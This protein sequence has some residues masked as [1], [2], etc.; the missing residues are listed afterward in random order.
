MIPNWK[1]SCV[2]AR[3]GSSGDILI[4]GTSRVLIYPVKSSVPQLTEAVSLYTEDDESGPR[5]RERQGPNT[6]RELTAGT[7]MA[8]V[9]LDTDREACLFQPMGRTPCEGDST[10]ERPGLGL[11]RG[12]LGEVLIGILCCRL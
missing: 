3:L 7:G 11:P 12:N 2:S 5:E 6:M 10:V 4:L 9:S 1:D 8:Q